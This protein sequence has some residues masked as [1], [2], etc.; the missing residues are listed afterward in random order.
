MLAYTAKKP[1]LQNLLLSSALI[2]GAG[3]E[4]SNGGFQ[5]LHCSRPLS[6]PA[7]S[8]PGKVNHTLI[9]VAVSRILL[10]DLGGDGDA[11]ERRE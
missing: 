1:V 2:Q 5:H 8:H 6:I 11:L 3:E 9:V 7:P 4:T 10:I